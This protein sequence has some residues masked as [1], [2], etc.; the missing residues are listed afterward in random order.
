MLKCQQIVGFGGLNLK[1]PLI[2]DVS[3]FM[4]S[5]NFMLSNVEH[6]KKFNNRG[7]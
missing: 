2:L 7:V 3:V 4:S 6:E 1:F 5:K